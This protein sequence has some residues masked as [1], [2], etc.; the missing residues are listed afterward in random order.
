MPH[1]DSMGAHHYVRT[2]E[3]KR[4]NAWFR[5]TVTKHYRFLQRCRH[6]PG[7][8]LCTKVARQQRYSGLVKKERET[9]DKGRETGGER[10]TQTTTASYSGKNASNF[11]TL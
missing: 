2:Q 11:K 9:T 8:I 7:I 1:I 5:G 10:E 4:P 6:F 3:P